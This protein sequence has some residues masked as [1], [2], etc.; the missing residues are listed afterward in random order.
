MSMARTH[1]VPAYALS[2]FATCIYTRIGLLGPSVPMRA[3]PTLTLP[4][5]KNL[6]ASSQV[7]SS[8]DATRVIEFIK[9]WNFTSSMVLT[10][11]VVVNE[12]IAKQ[13]IEGPAS[14]GASN[15][16]VVAQPSLSLDPHRVESVCHACV[17]LGDLNKTLG[18]KCRWVVSL[19]MLPFGFLSLVLQSCALSLQVDKAVSCHGCTNDAY[20][21]LL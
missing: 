15:C 10:G 16:S 19:S 8:A 21:A 1:R 7:E 13:G 6:P 18:E 3:P 9:S 5:N 14:I 17:D 2:N 4:L 11:C 20:S 12:T